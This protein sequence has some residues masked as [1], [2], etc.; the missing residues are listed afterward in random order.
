MPLIHSQRNH[1]A[2]YKI[3]IESSRKNLKI[4]KD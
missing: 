4:L 2:S 1:I 3:Q